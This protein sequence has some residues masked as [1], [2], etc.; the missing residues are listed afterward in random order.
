MRIMSVDHGCCRVSKVP[1]LW[2]F[3][4]AGDLSEVRREPI[5]GHFLT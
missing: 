2:S 3:F 1:R 5:A 4:G